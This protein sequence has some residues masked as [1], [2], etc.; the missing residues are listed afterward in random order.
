MSFSDHFNSHALVF[1][2]NGVSTDMFSNTASRYSDKNHLMIQ[3]R[4]VRTKLLSKWFILKRPGG[5]NLG[6]GCW[7]Q[8][9]LMTSFR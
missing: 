1:E 7:R 8:I 9:V 4:S 5:I 3:R 2:L 6:D